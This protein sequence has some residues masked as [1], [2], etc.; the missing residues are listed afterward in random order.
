MKYLVLAVL[1][2]AACKKPEPPKQEQS[3][4]APPTAQAPAGAVKEERM[5]YVDIAN[6]TGSVVRLHLNGRL[7]G[8]WSKSE[9]VDLP[10][11]KRGRNELEVEVAEPAEGDLRVYVKYTVRKDDH[12]T[13]TQELLKLALGDKPGK[14]SAVFNWK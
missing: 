4:A 13:T 11:A 12:S 14:H 2:L 8:A 5:P 9:R 3:A 7:V 10:K 1:I 6:Y